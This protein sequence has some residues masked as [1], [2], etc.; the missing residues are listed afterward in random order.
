MRGRGRVCTPAY[1]AELKPAEEEREKEKR[2][3]QRQTASNGVTGKTQKEEK[4]RTGDE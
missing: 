4:K 2:V 3:K 1:N